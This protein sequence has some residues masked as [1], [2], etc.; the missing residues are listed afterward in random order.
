MSWWLIV[1]LAFCGMEVFTA[2]FHRFVMHGPLW[3]IH[4][5]HHKPKGTL[6]ERNDVFV[7]FF[8]A[9]AMALIAL[10][11]PNSSMMW[12]GVGIAV[13]GVAY[14]L[15]HDVIIHKR[16]ARP[17]RPKNPYLV[18]VYRMHMAHHRHVDTPKGEAFGLLFV[19]PRYWK[20]VLR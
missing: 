1:L 9:S 12:I 17:P 4:H 8:T 5:S 7:L 11:Y 2:L 19:P 10:G 16:F 13:Y 18:A 6:L 20:Q 3:S 14:F 15:V